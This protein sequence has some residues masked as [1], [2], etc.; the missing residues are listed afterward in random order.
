MNLR[1]YRLV[2]AKHAHL[3][4]LTQALTAEAGYNPYDTHT[5]HV[6]AIQHLLSQNFGQ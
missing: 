4:G 1:M 5:T 3:W 6:Q 2:F